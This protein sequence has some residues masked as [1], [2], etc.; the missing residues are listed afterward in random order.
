[1][2]RARCAWIGGVMTRMLFALIALAAAA[3]AGPD[4]SA[5]PY[6][7]RTI[8]LVVP[9]PAGGAIDVM[10]RLLAQKL[11]ATF[12]SIIVENRPGGGGTVC[13]KAFFFSSRRRH[14]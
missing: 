8:K 13:L 6:P 3:L 12:G 7:N 1:M 2:G 10:A 14:T 4:A 11:S 5:Q 9:F